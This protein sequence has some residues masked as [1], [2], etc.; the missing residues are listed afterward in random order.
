VSSSRNPLAARLRVSADLGLPPA[1]RSARG[2]ADDREL[3]GG[4]FAALVEGARHRLDAGFGGRREGDPLR[5]LFLSAGAARRCCKAGGVAAPDAA[6]LQSCSGGQRAARRRQIGEVAGVS[7]L[8]LTLTRCETRGAGRRARSSRVRPAVDP[9]LRDVFG[10]GAPLAAPRANP[11]VSSRSTNP[12]AWLVP[13]ANAEEAVAAA[14]DIESLA[15]RLNGWVPTRKDVAA[16][17]PLV[18]ALL[19]QTAT[20]RSSRSR[21]SPSSTRSTTTWCSPPRGRRAAGASSF[22]TR[23][24]PSSRSNP[25]SARSG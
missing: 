6:P 5:Q 16:Y 14:N 19:E 17:L 18:H 13:V 10:F 9:E 22:A 15:K 4:F 11:L 21:S 2:R 23:R 24:A 7:A 20:Q 1:S 8:R 25:A 3:R 12:F